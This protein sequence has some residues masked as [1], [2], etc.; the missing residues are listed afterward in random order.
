MKCPYCG[1]FDSKVLDSRPMDDKIRRRRECLGCTRRFTTYEYLE[2]A[3]LMVVK[4]NKTRQEFDREKLLESFRRACVK[5][6]VPYTVLE[7][8]VNDIEQE[9]LNQQCREISS[10]KI[11]ELAMKKLL[12]IDDVAYVRFASVYRDFKDI[13]AFKAELD[14]IMKC[15]KENNEE[16]GGRKVR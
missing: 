10:E 6:D 3:P 16:D 15:R 8:T 4:R 12:A 5:R 14:N 11:G 13:D 1:Y 7:K 2:H 9:I